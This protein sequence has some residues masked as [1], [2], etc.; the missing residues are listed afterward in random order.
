MFLARD[1][2]Y[3]NPMLKTTNEISR[4][5]CGDIQD[6][7]SDCH[8]K[9]ERAESKVVLEHNIRGT[10][11]VSSCFTRREIIEDQ[12]FPLVLLVPDLAK[13]VYES[14]L[15]AGGLFPKRKARAVKTGE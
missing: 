7:A 6:F 10:S 9:S 14:G 4:R 8:G 15:K 12:S 13:T 3:G 1:A 11:C 5:W 2:S